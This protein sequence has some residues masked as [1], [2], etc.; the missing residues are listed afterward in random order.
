[1]ITLD[2]TLAVLAAG[3]AL[4]VKVL[5]QPHQFMVTR[6]RFKHALR[7]NYIGHGG[8]PWE[9]AHS[10]FY[11]ANAI[12]SYAFGSLYAGTHGL[13]ALAGPAA[14]GAVF[15]II[16]TTQDELCKRRLDIDRRLRQKTPPQVRRHLTPDGDRYYDVVMTDLGT[17]YV[18]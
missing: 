16:L 9:R 12:G 17:D 3:T 11:M 4:T 10:R 7:M 15:Q 14:L 13:W 18:K 5:G 6:K 8:A 1:M 2:A